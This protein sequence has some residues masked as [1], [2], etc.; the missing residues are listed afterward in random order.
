MTRLPTWWWILA[1][2]LL[3]GCAEQPAPTPSEGSTP[4]TPTKTQFKLAW[5]RY[6]GW[7]PWGYAAASGIVER[8]A[9]RKG[10]TIEVVYVDSYLGS[11][12]RYVSGEFDACTMTNIDALTL[13]AAQG[14]DSVALIVGDYSFG[15]DGIVL[16]NGS[17][18]TSLGGRPIHL[19]DGSV[20][21]FLLNR[22]AQIHG[23]DMSDLNLIDV[24]EDRIVAR[25]AADPRA[26]AVTWNPHLNEALR[27]PNAQLVF[28]S[29]SIP[30]EVLDLLL[31][32]ADGSDAFKE[33]LVGAW[34]ETLGRLVSDDAAVRSEAH[35]WIA[36]NVGV[37]ETEWLAQLESTAMFYY[38]WDAV[39]YTRS[40]ALVDAARRTAEFAERN[41]LA[42]VAPSGDGAIG[43]E[44]PNGV[45]L[46]HPERIR[47]R[48]TERY[49]QRASLGLLQ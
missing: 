11:I 7:E 42:M 43:I 21:E 30:G 44:L 15:N 1:L 10:I 18:V 45:V 31:V 4:A 48:Y 36:R 2:L 29:A 35:R 38:A 37:S 49:M 14:V 20:S 26:A 27:V 28:S 22:A 46:G 12:E 32:R 16:R 41:G 33:A 23:L 47:L 19:V 8:W 40:I 3:V 9:Q 39:G 25:L 34:Y 6:P 5:S 13:P 17:D 24:P